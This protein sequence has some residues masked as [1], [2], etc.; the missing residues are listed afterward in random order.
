MKL[1]VWEW[2]LIGSVFL[3]DQ[4][5]ARCE[6]IAFRDYSQPL[7]ILSLALLVFLYGYIRRVQAFLEIG[8]YLLLWICFVLVN[9]MS[10][11]AIAEWRLPLR[12]AELAGIDAMIGFN[13]TTALHIVTG[14]PWITELLPIAYSSLFAQTIFST[15]YFSLT[16]FSDRNRELFRMAAIA[17][18][19]TNLISGI[20]PAI[21]PHPPLA[22]FQQAFIEIRNNSSPYIAIPK[23]QG[24]VTFPSFHTALAVLFIYVHRPPSRSFF[25]VLLLNLFMLM[26][27]PFWG[28]HY[29]IDELAGASLALACIFAV[30][31][32]LKSASNQ[33]QNLAA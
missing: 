18:I 33:K 19:A 11:Y 4:I 23:M 21:G 17:C 5:L 12:D 26:A 8:E 20:L 28:H 9:A 32:C 30:T 15:V 31:K 7:F 1:R 25:P 29:F 2:Y 22:P 6:G 3:A 16:G 24:I 10:A 14:S 27:V 13:R